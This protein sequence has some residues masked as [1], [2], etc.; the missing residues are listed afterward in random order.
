LD[1]QTHDWM[2]KG[3]TQGL[4]YDPNRVKPGPGVVSNAVDRDDG[5]DYWNKPQHKP[6][7]PAER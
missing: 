4:Y 2:V 6:P 7:Y 5:G 3:T 1:Q